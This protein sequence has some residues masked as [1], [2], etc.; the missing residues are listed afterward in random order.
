MGVLKGLNKKTKV[1]MSHGDT[2]FSI[3][4]EYSVLASTENS[5]VAAF[6]HK[7]KPVFGL[8]W[9]PEVMHT[10]NGSQ[11]LRN[12][13]F[14]VCKCKPNW[15]MEDVIGKA[16]E[17]IRK[18]VGDGKAIIALSGGIDSS[19]ATALAA[20]ALDSRLT[21]VFV[22]HGFM[23]E[24]EPDFVEKVFLKF[25]INLVITDA[26]E[27]FL[28][29]LEGI[30]DPEKKR[31]KIGEEFIRVFEETAEKTGAEYLIQGTI[32]P[33]RIESGIRKFSDKIKTHHNVAGIPIRIKF[34]KI[35]EPLKDLYKTKLER[36]L[37]CLAYQR[38]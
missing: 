27:R 16:T 38:R 19:V 23:R 36:F 33:D 17:E 9:H 31:K 6:K 1:W 15:K 7:N 12:F 28:A 32:Y 2:V 24:N 22:D 5:P 25:N 8:Q 11:M 30:V 14:E 29:K 34:T 21:A 35:V 20:K 26:I 10:E 18:E 13:I 37:K 4:S 3:P